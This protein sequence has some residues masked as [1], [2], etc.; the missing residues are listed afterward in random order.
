M[1]QVGK[2]RGIL[3]NILDEFNLL[4]IFEWEK[5]LTY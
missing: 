3:F 4:D 1:K 2:K 5:K